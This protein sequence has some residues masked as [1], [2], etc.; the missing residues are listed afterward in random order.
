[1][2]DL[3]IEN[4]QVIDGLGGPAQAGGVA[5]TDGRITALGKDLGAARERIDAQGQVLAPGIIDLHTHYDA[6]LTWDAFATPS[7]AN[8]V[9][10][11][12]IGNCGF[13]IAPCKP[14][15]RELNARNLAYVEGMPIEALQAGIDW[16]FESYPEYLDS[17]ER[18]GMVPNVASFCGH[19]SVRVNVMGKDAMKRA[20]TAEEVSQMQK[21]VL[22]ALDAGAIGFATSTL[23]QHNGVD[24]IPMPSRFADEHEMMTLTGTL[25][26]KD[27]GVFMLTKGM[28]SSVPWLEE[29][30]GRNGRPVMIC[31]MFS[32]PNDPERVVREFGEIAAARKRGRELW[33]QVASYPLGMEFSLALPYPLH[34][35]ISWRPAMESIGTPRYLELFADQ[36]FRD[37]VKAEALTTSVPVRFSYHSFRQMR[38]QEVADPKFDTLVGKLVPDLAKDAG[39]DP[40]DWLLDHALAGGMNTTFDCKLFNIDDDR[41]RDL[42]VDPHSAL[43]L[44]DA[45]AHL[46]FLCDA[47][48]GLHLLGHWVRERGDLT[49]EQAV[50]MLT[51]RLADAYRIPDRGRLV[52]GAHADMMMFDANKVGRGEKT[53]VS[54]LPAG[55]SRV[56]IPPAG[57]L[58]VWVNGVRVV[59]ESGPVTTCGK[60]GNLIRKFAA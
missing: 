32:D 52:P 27:K 6:Q 14:E 35:L 40:F 2:H 5:V 7:P 36:S 34:A 10:T 23:E 22:E 18:K 57:V 44:G 21:I 11:V 47:G 41:V 38:V 28:T 50:Q 9:T 53:R 46:S 48:F 45:G 25:G 54:D 4:A 1:M 19:S 17:L 58:G 55:A 12:V 37:A 59:D 56:D 43:G 16:D 26:E 51:S 42:L 8:G 31:A 24:G 49:L 29:I 60:P 13:T 15:H 39:Q 20:A 30:A 3:V 33:G